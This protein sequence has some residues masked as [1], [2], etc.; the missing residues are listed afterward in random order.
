[1]RILRH[2]VGKIIS[3]TK[4]S[5]AELRE[6]KELQMDIRKHLDRNLLV[7]QTIRGIEKSEVKNNEPNS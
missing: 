4:I 6:A 3:Q 1:M 7:R 5:K 2:Q